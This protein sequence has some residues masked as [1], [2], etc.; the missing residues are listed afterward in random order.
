[1]SA[2]SRSDECETEEEGGIWPE[3]IAGAARWM[4]WE[5][6]LLRLD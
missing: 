6:F 4:A 5:M 3:L 2:D 1:M